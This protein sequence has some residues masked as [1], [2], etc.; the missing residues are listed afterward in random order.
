MSFLSEQETANSPKKRFV[1]AV[2][3]DIKLASVK[4]E[5]GEDRGTRSDMI[6]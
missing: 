3:E 2:K 4:E 5:V 1:N 6:G